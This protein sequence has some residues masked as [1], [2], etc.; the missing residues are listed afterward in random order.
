M[1]AGRPKRSRRPA[2]VRRPRRRWTRA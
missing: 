1:G 2:S